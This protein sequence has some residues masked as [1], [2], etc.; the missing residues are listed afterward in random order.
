MSEIHKSNNHFHVYWTNFGYFFVIPYLNYSQFFNEPTNFQFQPPKLSH[1]I[2]CLSSS[3]NIHPN[4]L[5]HHSNDWWGRCVC[6]L[7]HKCP[8]QQHRWMLFI[9]IISFFS[10]FIKIINQNYWLWEKA[11]TMKHSKVGIFLFFS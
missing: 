1:L 10:H 2:L 3:H 8:L 9:N 6:L 11:S 7:L 5:F 4:L